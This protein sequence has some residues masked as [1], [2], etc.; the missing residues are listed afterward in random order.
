MTITLTT[1][2]DITLE[3]YEAVAWKGEAVDLSDAAIDKMTTCRAAFEGLIDQSDV[4]IYG[5]TSGYGQQ[6]GLRFTPEERR[7]HAR[8]GMG[9]PYVNFGPA[10]PERVARGIALARLANFIDGFA[11]VSPAVAQAVAAMLGGRVMPPVPRDGHGG[12]GEITILTPLFVDLMNEVELHEKDALCLVNGSPGGAALVAD[13]VLSAARRID[14]AEE[15]FALSAE[16]LGMPL[17]HVDPTLETLWTDE[18]EAASVRNLRHLLAD[19]AE[20]RRSYQAPT[21][22]RILPRMLG[23]LRRD[24]ATARAAAE[25]SLCEVSENPIYL[26][27]DADHPHGR[28]IST[29]GYHNT[30]AWPAMNGLAMA[31]ADLITLAGRHLDRLL[32]GKYSPAPPDGRNFQATYLGCLGMAVTGYGEAAKRAASGTF[33]PGPEQG[34]FEANDTSPPNPLAWDGQDRAGEMLDRSLA[35]LALAA[36]TT[37][38]RIDRPAPPALA[39]RFDTLRSCIPE[40]I[41]RNS[42]GPVAEAIFGNFRTDIFPTEIP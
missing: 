33:M 30:A 18:Y 19:G 23:R 12:A 24:V 27:P 32:G 10:F 7:A 25:N 4:V 3:I 17:E 41:P 36:V 37:L 34:G 16:A 42:P 21:S 9:P 15:V 40:F 38:D 14:L 13:A 22:F 6:A 2:N 26:P 1:R 31:Y 39:G 35:S 8:R 11:A 20:G 28:T 5:V 29:G